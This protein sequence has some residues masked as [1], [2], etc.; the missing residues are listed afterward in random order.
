MTVK[1]NVRRAYYGVQLARD[2]LTLLRD[3][4]VASTSTSVA[5]KEGQQWGRG[6][7]RALELKMYR[8]ELEGEE[9]EATPRRQSRCRLQH[10]TATARM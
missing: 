2:A 10:L 5:S 3:A 4:R 7:H 6:R 8:A 9:S 1:L